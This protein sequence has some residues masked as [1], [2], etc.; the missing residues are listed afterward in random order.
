MFRGE[1]LEDDRI[2]KLAVN[3]YRYESGL[4]AQNL[5]KGKRSWESSKSIRDMIVEYFAENSP[6]EPTVDNNWRIVGVDLSGDDPRRAEIIGY[7]NEG[8]LPTPY[9]RSC[10][11][12]DYDELVAEA[13]ANR[14]AGKTVEDQ[15]E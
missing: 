15:Q 11:L 4:K 9:N 8:L 14:A 13:Q 5:V 6:V 10:N 7:I 12:V 1:P 3:H 2:L